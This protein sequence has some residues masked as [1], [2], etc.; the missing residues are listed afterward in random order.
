MKRSNQYLDLELV[1]GVPLVG[2]P[3]VQNVRILAQGPIARTGDIAN[4]H[5]P[6]FL[7]GNM[8][9][10]RTRVSNPFVVGGGGCLFGG[11][12]LCVLSVFE[13]HP[14]SLNGLP[15]GFQTTLGDIVGEN[16]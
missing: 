15:Q 16:P 11:C 6:Q 10:I 8:T 3:Q 12:V 1:Q 5:V 7:R 14:R 4:H 9:G 13:W 2:F